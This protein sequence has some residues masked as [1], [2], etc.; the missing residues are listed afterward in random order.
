M[1]VVGTRAGKGGDGPKRKGG[2]VASGHR[3]GSRGE[4]SETSM[5][6]RIKVE[7]TG[8][9]S[10]RG[11]SIGEKGF[12][13]GDRGGEE[14]TGG[15]LT[16]ME[17]DVVNVVGV[18]VGD[19]AEVVKGVEGGIKGMVVRGLLVELGAVEVVDGGKRSGGRAEK[20]VTLGVNGGR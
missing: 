2:G 12:A 7:S 15:L 6:D 13:K 1:D 11:G 16:E 19:V 14:A 20:E 9:W 3:G 18:E 10:G 4:G 5:G 8:G 17:N